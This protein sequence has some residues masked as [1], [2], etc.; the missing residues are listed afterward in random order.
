VKFTKRWTA[1]VSALMCALALSACTSD[2]STADGGRPKLLLLSQ[3]S[4]FTAPSY[5]ALELGYYEDAG[6]DVEIRAF[7]SGT[8][9][10]EAWTSGIGDVIYSGGQPALLHYG[11]AGK[12]DYKMIQMATRSPEDLIIMARSD[13][14]TAED[15]KGKKVATRVGSTSEWWLDRYLDHHGMTTDDVEVIN[16]DS[17]QMA[18]AIANGDIDAFALFQPVGWQA[19]AV[20]G[21]SIHQLADASE[22][23]GVSDLTVY[24]ARPKWLDDDPETMQKFLDATQRGAEYVEENIDSVGDFYADE[25]GADKEQTVRTIEFFDFNPA[26]DEDARTMLD[27]L[28]DWSVEQGSLEEPIDLDDA[29]WSE[30]P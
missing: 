8:T 13:I 30:A 22:V 14:E 20:A 2:D 29:I 1:I 5:M 21:D 6:I 4:P 25:F 7:P 24:G 23:P 15:L 18:P 10:L 27:D 19:E 9:A 17:E 12:A 11:S 16:L 26:F 3:Q 28:V